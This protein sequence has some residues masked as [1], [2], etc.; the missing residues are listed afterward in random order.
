MRV[1]GRTIVIVYQC[2]QRGCHV[3]ALYLHLYIQVLAHRGLDRNGAPL[4]SKAINVSS[5]VYIS[6]Y[7][8]TCSLLRV[9]SSV[10]RAGSAAVKPEPAP[11]LRSRY[12]LLS[13]YRYQDFMLSHFSFKLYAG[14]GIFSLIDASFFSIYRPEFWWKVKPRP[15]TSVIRSLF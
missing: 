6:I 8:L 1:W 7:L 13:V 2:G 11:P 5:L 3:G 4:F 9:R 14:I 12:V 10:T 15:K